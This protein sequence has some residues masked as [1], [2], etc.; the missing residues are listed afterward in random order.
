[1]EKILDNIKLVFLQYT[2]LEKQLDILISGYFQT[3][4]NAQ[5]NFIAV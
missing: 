1:M 3:V 2:V 4:T 5:L